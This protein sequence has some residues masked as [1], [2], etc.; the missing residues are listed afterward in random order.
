M[1]GG[2]DDDTQFGGR[3][4]DVIFANRG[5]D[6]SHGGG[7]N[8]VLWALA[9]AD[10][11]SIG[12][13]VGDEVFGDRGRDLFRVRDG[14]VDEVHCGPGLDRVIADQFDAVD[15]D[16]DQVE[17]QHLTELSQVQDEPENATESP[18]EDGEQ[19]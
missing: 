8:D 1:S 11:T 7:G 4:R 6:T 18:G 3:G 12:D 15:V 17:R 13:P 16:C 2:K 9:R 5:A 10:V 14:E 19:K